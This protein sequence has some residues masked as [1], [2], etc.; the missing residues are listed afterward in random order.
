MADWIKMRANLLT[1]AKVIKMARLLLQD[2]EFLAWFAPGGV[3]LQACDAVTLRHVTVVTRVTV[4]GLLPVWA[5]VNAD[6]ERHDDR[7]ALLRDASL[8]E[9]D[10]IAGIPGFG[11]AM[12]AV[13]WLHQTADGEGLEFGNFIE[14]NTVG[15]ERSSGAKTTAQRAKEYRERQKLGRHEIVTPTVTESSVTNRDASRDAVTTE[16][17]REEKKSTP[18]APKG[19]SQR[20]EDFWLAW[21]KSER[22]QDKAKCSEKWARDGLDAVA[23][24]ILADIRAKRGTQKWREDGG[25]Y[26]EAPAVYLNN[27]RWEDGNAD[28][29]EQAQESFV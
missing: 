4:G 1:N 3:T 12:E 18:K 17:N 28:P 11:R 8:F 24:T 2:A 20:F 25:K 6:A 21:P 15:K 5:S 26:I 19:A 10:Q 27:R 13:G 23:D 14:H 22:K 9:V 16:K 7:H 29:A